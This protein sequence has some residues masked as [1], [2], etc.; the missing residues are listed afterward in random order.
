M[1]LTRSIQDADKNQLQ[2]EISQHW[3]KRQTKQHVCCTAYSWHS[4]SVKT[5]CMSHG[6]SCQRMCCTARHIKTHVAQ[7]SMA[8][9]LTQS[10]SQAAQHC[11]AHQSTR[12]TARH[13]TGH[14]N[15]RIACCT[16]RHTISR[17]AEHGTSY[18][19]EHGAQPRGTYAT[20][21]LVPRFTR[22]QPTSG[23]QRRAAMS[24]PTRVRAR[25]LP[26]HISAS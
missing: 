6:T 2:S 1:Q 16:V 4:I 24:P 25:G 14:H 15:I 7:Q 5:K 13:G 23:V 26:P 20:F 19:M 9:C 10:G 8:H 12:I 18:H 17:A 3:S 21:N 11:M 22:R